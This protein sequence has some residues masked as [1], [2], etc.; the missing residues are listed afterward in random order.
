MVVM[1]SLTGL[2][3]AGCK[4]NSAG[5]MG[6]YPPTQVVAVEAKRQPVSENLSLV[7]TVA[8]DEMVEIHS[9]IDGTVQEIKFEEGK[10]VEK[11]QMLVQL[12]PTKLAASVAEAESNFKLSQS[13]YDRVKTLLKDNII[14][15]QEF[16]QAASVYEVNKALL[17]RKKRELK[18]T[19]IFAPFTGVMSSRMISPGQVINKDSKLTWLVALDPVK[20]EVN[21]P[22]RFLSQVQVG[23][24]IEVTVAAYPKEKFNGEVFFIAPQIDPGTRTALI[25]ARIPN[26]DFRLKPGMFA[27]LDLTL[28]IKENAVVI[29]ES[30]LILN[31][32][33]TS[34]CIA[35]QN[36]TN[37]MLTAQFKMVKVGIRMAGQ[38]EI[39][40]GLQGGEKVIVEGYQKTRPGAPVK[41]ASAGESK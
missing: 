3:F 30:A 13:N 7:G 14:G 27:N 26:A 37:Q 23:Q 6:S 28:R 15:Q 12:D 36:P 25:K 24:K 40:D 41:L 2:V 1:L 4:K 29:P 34:I 17:D 19:Q 9:E 21:V 38:V 32:D 22:E 11:G 39:T 33:S 18:D 20:I 35:E 31:G 5:M 10:P 16:D 8:A